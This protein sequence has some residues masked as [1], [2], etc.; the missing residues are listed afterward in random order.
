MPI[1]YEF[2]EK[3]ITLKGA[4]TASA[5]RIGEALADIKQRTTGIC[6]SKTVL[7]AAR[8]PRHYLHRFFEWRDTVAA[9]KYR[10]EQARELMS[11]IDLVETKANKEKRLPAFV[12]IM[13]KGGRSYYAIQEVVSSVHLQDLALKQAE[14]DMEHYER[15]LSQFA[16]IARAIARARQLIRERRERYSAMGGDPTFS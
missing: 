16:E 13:D 2:K 7:D 15:R 4:K 6:N 5:Q 9:E 1:R 14:A 10:Q 8:S 11:C 12:S 3:P